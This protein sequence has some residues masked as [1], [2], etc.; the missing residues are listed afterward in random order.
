MVRLPER[1]EDVESNVQRD[2]MEPKAQ[3]LKRLVNK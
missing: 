2:I 1:E 3:I